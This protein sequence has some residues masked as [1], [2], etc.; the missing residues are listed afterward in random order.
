M[1]RARYFGWLR[2]VDAVCSLPV[3]A[4]FAK[5]AKLLANPARSA[6]VGALLDGRAMTGTELARIAGVRP[7]TASEHLGELVRGQLVLVAAD[8]RRRYF[9]LAATEV[10]EALEALARICPPVQPRSP[11]A[12]SDARALGFARTCYDHLAGTLG[13]ALLEALLTDSWLAEDESGFTATPCGRERLAELEIDV[14]ALQRQRRSFARPC[15]D[16]TERRPH[17]GG[18]LGAAIT[19]SLLQKRWVEREPRRRSVRLTS[20]GAT[21]LRSLLSLDISTP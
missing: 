7:S 8:G 18:A 4:D 21:Q 10:A 12:S 17:L 5:V 15:L 16:W 13:V 20:I 11:R 1:I 3:D 19:T 6:M 14:S 9:S 2:S